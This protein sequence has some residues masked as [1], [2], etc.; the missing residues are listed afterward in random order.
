MASMFYSSHLFRWDM[1]SQT[2][3]AFLS[4]HLSIHY[5]MHR[6]LSLGTFSMRT[7]NE[8]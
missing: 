8:T 6:T 5:V 1:G 7:L 4:I 3:I 2:R